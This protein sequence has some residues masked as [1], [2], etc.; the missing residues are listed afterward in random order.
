VKTP[1]LIAAIVA[2]TSICS[3]SFAQTDTQLTLRPWP[4]NT[5]GETDDHPTYQAQSH[6]RG[7]DASA[8]IFWYDSVG[9]FRLTGPH[10]LSIGYRWVTMNLDTNSSRLPDH[11]DELSAAVGGRVDEHLTLIG[12]AGYSGNN[13]FADSNGVFGIGHVTWE[14]PTN[15]NGSIALSLDYNGNASLFPDVPLP[16]VELVHRGENVSFGVG[17]P[18][19]WI[20]WQ[21]LPKLSFD[22][23]YAVPYT[24]SARLEYQITPTLSVFGQ[25]A[26]FYNA[27][28]IQHQT[29]TDRLF[30]QM[31]QAELGVRYRKT[32]KG[33]YIDAALVGG[34]AFEQ[35]FA[36]GFDVRDLDPVANV[37]DAPYIGIILGGRF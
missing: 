36:H 19:D 3:A 24:A 32:W 9:R 16:G 15:A 33:I 30:F 6:V 26:N 11:L 20:Q 4:W 22:A 29:R 21:I 25:G 34:Y 7:E 5:W 2:V 18:N 31:S 12:G 37:S 8:Q 1:G 27:F 17:F 28:A 13:P 23:R 35:R 10:A 14:T